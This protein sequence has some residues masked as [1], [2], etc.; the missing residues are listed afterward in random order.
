MSQAMQRRIFVKRTVGSDPVV[1]PCVG[2]QKP[3]KM[4]LA[5]DDDMV[6]AILSNGPNQ[7]FGKAVLPRRPWR[8]RFVPNAHSAQAL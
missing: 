1:V 2:A 6:Q 8:D 7:P 4:G 5:E 3:A